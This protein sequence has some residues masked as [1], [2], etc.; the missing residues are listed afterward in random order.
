MVLK[1]KMDKKKYAIGDNIKRK[2][3][4]MSGNSLLGCKVVSTVQYGAITNNPEEMLP[5]NLC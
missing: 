5:E 1:I 2:Q 4:G 3:N